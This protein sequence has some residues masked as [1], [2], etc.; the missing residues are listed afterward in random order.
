MMTSSALA[1]AGGPEFARWDRGI[2]TRLANIQRENGTWRGD[3]C[4]TST[5]FCTAAALI[6]LS[7]HANAKAKS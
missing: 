4:I 6:T 2:R 5:S 1:A 3:H 7:I